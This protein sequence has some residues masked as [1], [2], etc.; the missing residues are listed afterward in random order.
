MD[1]SAAKEDSMFNVRS[2]RITTIV[3]SIANGEIAA[4]AGV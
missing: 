2:R 1:R 3:Q 4:L